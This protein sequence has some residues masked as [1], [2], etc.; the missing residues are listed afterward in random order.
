[1]YSIISLR[2]ITNF[3]MI[4]MLDLQAGFG[5]IEDLGNEAKDEEGKEEVEVEK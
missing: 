4:K 2:R 5:K 3:G 1:M